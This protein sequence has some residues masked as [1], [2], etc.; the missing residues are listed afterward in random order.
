MTDRTRQIVEALLKTPE[1]VQALKQDPNAFAARFGLGERELQLLQSGKRLISDFASRLL[2]QASSHRGAVSNAN[3]EPYSARENGVANTP[4]SPSAAKSSSTVAL[5]GV[6]GLA[7]I[8]GMLVALGTVS[9]V[10]INS[11][12]CSD[13]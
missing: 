11:T 2:S 5:V 1:L 12:G 13:E 10:G 8:T 9:V 6:T 7:A 4:G 3:W